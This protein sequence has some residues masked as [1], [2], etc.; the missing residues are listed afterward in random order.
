MAPGESESSVGSHGGSSRACGGS[1]KIGAS[2]RIG[3]PTTRC[4]LKVRM[5]DHDVVV[6][7]DLRCSASPAYDVHGRRSCSRPSHYPLVAGLAGRGAAVHDRLNA[8]GFEDE[9]GVGGSSLRPLGSRPLFPLGLGGRYHL[10]SEPCQRPIVGEPPNGASSRCRVS[11]P[12]HVDPW[13]HG[14]QR[15]ER[16]A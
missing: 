5:V 12:R 6:G 1:S 10:P 4:F 8:A 9:A 2:L 7:P 3:M 13:V 15:G 16:E 14:A 11:R